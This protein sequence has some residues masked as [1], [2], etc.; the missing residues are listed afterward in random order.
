MVDGLQN[1][2]LLR[3][4]VFLVYV[5][6]INVPESHIYDIED[7]NIGYQFLRVLFWDENDNLQVDMEA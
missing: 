3:C 4:D 1:I 6:A 2:M 5:S 7:M